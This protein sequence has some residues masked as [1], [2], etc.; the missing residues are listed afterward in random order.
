MVSS[1]IVV[2]A[3]VPKAMSVFL[4]RQGVQSPV[5]GNRQ[6]GIPGNE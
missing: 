1:G 3:G 4:S 6:K 5:A 2:M